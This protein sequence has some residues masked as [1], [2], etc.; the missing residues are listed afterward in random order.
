MLKRSHDNPRKSLGILS[1]NLRGKF[2]RNAA[3]CHII[4]LR[5]RRTMRLQTPDSGVKKGMPADQ[6]G[7]TPTASQRG[8]EPLTTPSR[9]L[10]R[11]IGDQ[12]MDKALTQKASL[13]LHFS[14]GRSNAPSRLVHHDW[15]IKS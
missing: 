15:F 12:P 6:I 2:D 1:D 3:F 10:S 5:L 8:C 4:G 14:A 9:H 7:H 13:G 11:I